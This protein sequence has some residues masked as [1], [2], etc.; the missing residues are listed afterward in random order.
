MSSF[1]L[2]YTALITPFSGWFGLDG[3]C[4]CGSAVVLRF[5]FVNEDRRIAVDPVFFLTL[6]FFARIYCGRIR[7]ITYHR[8]FS[9]AELSAKE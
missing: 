8:P 7:T 4:I 6:S 5:L 9:L 3:V 2:M 1:L